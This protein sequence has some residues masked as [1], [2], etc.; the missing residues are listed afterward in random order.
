MPRTS[1]FLRYHLFRT[2][3][4]AYMTE[5][6]SSARRTNPVTRKRTPPNPAHRLAALAV[7]AAMEKKAE[8]VSVLDLRGISGVADYFVLATGSSDLQIRA[9]ANAIQDEIEETCDER[10]WHKEGLEHLK[11]VLL[12]YVDVVVHIFTREKR[13]HYGLERLWGEAE[14]ESVPE[15]GDSED[16]PFLQETASPARQTGST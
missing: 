14:V 7:D 8:N 12:D 13:E 9:I 15:D 2:D 1:F 10:P 6:T 5:E 11:W 4:I 16:V 3:C